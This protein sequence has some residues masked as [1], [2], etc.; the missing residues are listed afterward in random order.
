MAKLSEKAI[1]KLFVLVLAINMLLQPSINAD[2]CALAYG[3]WSPTAVDMLVHSREIDFFLY[4]CYV[5]ISK[6]KC[7]LY[8][9][10]DAKFDLLLHPQLTIHTHLCVCM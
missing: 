9:Y 2:H 8:K 5:V 7:I 1:T 3:C 10:T 6:V 4:C